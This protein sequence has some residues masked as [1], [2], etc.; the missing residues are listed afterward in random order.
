MNDAPKG[1]VTEEVKED[2]EKVPDFGPELPRGAVKVME[3]ERVHRVVKVQESRT[4]LD[5]AKLE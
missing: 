2:G 4:G 5:L 1:E 3:K